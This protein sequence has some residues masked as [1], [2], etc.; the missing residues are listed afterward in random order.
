MEMVWNGGGRRLWKW[1]V[2]GLRHETGKRACPTA[3]IVSFSTE[4]SSSMRMHFWGISNL[5]SLAALRRRERKERRRR[6]E[7]KSSTRSHHASHATAC[8][9]AS[10][11]VAAAVAAVAATA[12]DRPCRCRCR[13]HLLARHVLLTLKLF[14]EAVALDDGALERRHAKLANIDAQRRRARTR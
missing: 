3:V 8:A 6:K 14:G 10:S 12:H 2:E 4:N 9:T 1:A 11:A 13:L 7:G 5:L